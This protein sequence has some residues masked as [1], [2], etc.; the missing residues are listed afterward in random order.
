MAKQL[1]SAII[2]RG[3]SL[4]DDKPIFVVATSGSK[5]DKTGNML[6]TWILRADVEPHIAVKNDDDYT[7]CG[8]CPHKGG[9][10]CYVT[11]FQAPLSVFRAAERGSYPDVSGDDAAIAAIGENRKVRVGAYGDPAAVPFEVWE[12]LL[13]RAVSNTGY[14]HQAHN[15][16]FDDRLANIC[17]ISAETPKQAQ[18]YHAR[19]WRTF[20][21]TSDTSAL[22]PGEEICA[23]DAYG[24]TCEAC[25]KCDG[26]AKPG[27]SQVVKIH[28]AKAKRFAHKN[29]SA[30]SI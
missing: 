7:I 16:F 3:S 8:T 19:G 5:N 1:K 25:G 28:G 15:K 6:Q 17:M 11:V 18:K 26:A 9:R 23:S 24:A 27:K 13:S 10:G 29:I 22:L 2:Y 4:S 12:A 30:S 21:A 14:T 20:R